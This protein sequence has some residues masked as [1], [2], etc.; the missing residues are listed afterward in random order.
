MG[1]HLSMKPATRPS[2]PSRMTDAQKIKRT[3]I[4]PL[5]IDDVK[6]NVQLS[7]YFII[8][9]VQCVEVWHSA[10]DSLQQSISLKSK[11]LHKWK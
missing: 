1:N 4:M 2:Q 6:N 3:Q 5:I 8:I 11:N 10:D 9:N 7:N